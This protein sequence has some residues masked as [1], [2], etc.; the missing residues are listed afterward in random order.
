[1]QPDRLVVN[2]P[3]ALGRNPMYVE[4]MLVHLG[5]A[6]VGDTTWPLVLSPVVAAAVHREV[7][8]EQVLLTARF[9]AGC[10]A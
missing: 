2:G 9:G 10:E 8:R 7:R 3:Y 1:M 6:A 4:G 5:A